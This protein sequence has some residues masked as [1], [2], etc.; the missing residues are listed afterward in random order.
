MEQKDKKCLGKIVI[1][2]IFI[3]VKYQCDEWRGVLA[4]SLIGIPTPINYPHFS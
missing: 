2:D 1:E 4:P 3:W